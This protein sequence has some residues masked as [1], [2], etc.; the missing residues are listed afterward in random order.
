MMPQSSFALPLVKQMATGSNWAEVLS[1]VA[2]AGA[3][4][5]AVAVPLTSYARRPSLSLHADEDGIHSRFEGNGLPYV[6]LVAKNKR[7]RRAAER[8][9]ALLSHY[10]DR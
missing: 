9:R 6:R 3:V 7:R 10:A 2:A 4:V 1:A 5:A 8:T